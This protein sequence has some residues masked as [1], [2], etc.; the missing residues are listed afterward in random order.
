M[1]ENASPHLLIVDDD[2]E[3][4]AMLAEFLSAEGFTCEKVFS[5]LDA[6]PLIGRSRFDAVILDVM[7]PGMPGTEV[8][9]RIRQISEVPVIMLT[10]RGDDLERVIGLELGADDYIAKPFFPREL[11]ARL[12][13]VLRRQ[14]QPDPASRAVLGNG[15]LTLSTQTHEAWIDDRLL[16]LT[17]SEFNV[18][19]ALLANVGT[20]LT[21]DELSL[22]ALKRPR[23]PYDRSI[24]VHVSNLRM[25]LGS[26]VPAEHGLETVRGVGYRIVKVA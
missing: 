26:T 2:I 15:R 4:V 16:D 18:L 11:V 21:K 19:A 22:L 20:V 3:H 1:R 9:K 8:L 12:R 7:L 6:C 17:V 25:K 5:G 23:T 24:D 14:A 13:A 10:A